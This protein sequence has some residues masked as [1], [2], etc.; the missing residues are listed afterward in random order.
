MASDTEKHHSKWFTHWRAFGFYSTK[1]C[2][3][4]RLRSSHSLIK[5]EPQLTVTHSPLL[6]NAK[7]VHCHATSEF[8]AVAQI[9][10]VQSTKQNGCCFNRNRHQPFS[11]SRC[12]MLISIKANVSISWFQ[13]TTKCLVKSTILSPVRLSSARQQRS[14]ASTSKPSRQTECILVQKWGSEQKPEDA[15]LLTHA[16]RRLLRQQEASQH[17]ASRSTVFRLELEQRLRLIFG[18]PKR[19]RQNIYQWLNDHMQKQNH[20]HLL[21]FARHCELLQSNR[22]GFM[23]LL[24]CRVIKSDLRLTFT[25]QVHGKQWTDIAMLHGCCSSCNIMSETA[26]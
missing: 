21:A 20:V 3:V 7:A 19:C 12:A 11:R 13:Q 17:L 24:A 10:Y 18:Q 6:E 4:W 8:L 9:I 23:S 15:Q 1:R 5:R 2:E 25:V 16:V 26:N 14:L 22:P